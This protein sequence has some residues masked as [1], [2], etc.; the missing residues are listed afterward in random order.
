MSL[1]PSSYSFIRK[2]GGS[3]V[4]STLDAR[5]NPEVVAGQSRTRE[6]KGGI[7]EIVYELG[8]DSRKQN[9]M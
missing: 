3:L 8:Y 7:L 6:A 9:I 4:S 5:R 2:K 1:I